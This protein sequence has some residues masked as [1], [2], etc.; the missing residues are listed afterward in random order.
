M[1]RSQ[2]PHDSRR[3]AR[4]RASARKRRSSYDE[5]RDPRFSQAGA[6]LAKAVIAMAVIFCARLAWLQ[7]FDA[8][9]LSAMAE[10]RSTN[11]VTLS[12]RRG[13]I[14]DRNGNILAASEDCST[15]YCNPTE[16]DDEVSVARSLANHLGGKASDFHDA[17]T[18]D[19]TFSYVAKRVST[20]DAD[21]ILGEL[22]EA[23]V[24]GLYEL[25]DVRRI[26]P[27]GDV[28]G[29][30][31]GLVG[32]DGHGLTGLELY[33]D[34]VLSGEDGSRVMEVGL[35]GTPVAGGA[36]HETPAIDGTDIVISLDM[37]VQGAVERA[38]AEAPDAYGATGAMGCVM[39]PETGE[40][41]G[42]A[43]T[44][45][46]AAGDAAHA[47]QEALN[48]GFLTQS[49]EPGSV[50]KVFTTAIGLETGAFTADTVW[51]VPW[52]MP[53][54]TIQVTDD[55]DRGYDMDMDAA[56]I[57]RRSSNVGA[58]V[59]AQKIGGETLLKGLRSFG[60]GEPTGIDFPGETAGIVHE[61]SEWDDATLN[62]MAFGQGYSVPPIQIV[63]AVAAVANH[64]V[65]V[66][67][68]FLIYRGTE[69]VEWP[70]AGRA[71]TPRTA[72]AVAEMLQ[73]VVDD[74]TAPA[75]A[76]E[77]FE[78][79]GK[80]GT[81]QKADLEHGGY[82]ENDLYS[83][84]AGFVGVPN[85]ELV[86]YVGVDGGILHG[87]ESA[88]PCFSQLMG[89]TLR[90]LAVTPDAEG[91]TAADLYRLTTADDEGASGYDGSAG[92]GAV[93]Y[94][95]AIASGEMDP[96]EL[97][98]YGGP[99]DEYGYIDTDGDYVAYAWL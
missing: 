85:A 55:D 13:T 83:S 94:A 49:F 38:I 59:E 90:D 84:F 40:I 89:E 42:M 35:G 32:D 66:T 47:S 75:A 98:D 43:S 22:Q 14:Y 69:K 92:D 23:G 44:P 6:F 30:I 45:L 58:M 65:L 11:E 9:R 64:G 3:K 60:I 28:A 70:V 15:L 2:R 78:V 74:G 37:E 29:Q 21:A 36:Y 10:S 4:A 68:H 86:G 56:E 54:G 17:L 52:S 71:C 53:S 7:V 8:G 67:P 51:N 12:A 99:G 87:G 96:S 77:G 97:P 31:L 80:T 27:Y 63:R 24:A 41:L 33:Y 95:G 16:I 48:L 73:G 79:A 93:D 81:A 88:A 91:Y 20:E 50:S 39:D 57:L 61:M 18:A 76:I 5:G 25:P 26:Y 46:L 34:D 1:P 19:T 62:S 82:L 72:T